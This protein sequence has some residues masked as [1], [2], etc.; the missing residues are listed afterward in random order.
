ME[1]NGGKMAVV[2]RRIE[3]LGNLRV[4]PD[5]VIC[6]IISSLSPPDVARLSCVSRLIRLSFLICRI[7]SF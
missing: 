5:E 7:S 6:E 1:N 3:A 4:L 2:D